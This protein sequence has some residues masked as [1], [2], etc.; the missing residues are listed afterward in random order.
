MHLFVLAL[1]YKGCPVASRGRAR[2]VEEEGEGNWAM[3]YRFYHNF[4]GNWVQ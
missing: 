1:L 2:A 4:L 3:E